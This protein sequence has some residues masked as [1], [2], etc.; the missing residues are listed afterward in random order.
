MCMEF[1]LFS[2]I[3]VLICLYGLHAQSVELHD[4]PRIKNNLL[5]LNECD[6]L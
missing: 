1:F 3:L 5:T 6:R 2:E 4:A